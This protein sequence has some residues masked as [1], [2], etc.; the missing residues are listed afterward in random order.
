[1]VSQTARTGNNY[2]Y[3]CKIR[4]ASKGQAARTCQTEQDG[5]N[6]ISMTDMIARMWNPR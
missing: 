3:L 2:F 5:T 6:R 4:S 1:M